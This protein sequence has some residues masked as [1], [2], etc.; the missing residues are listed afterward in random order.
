MPRIVP[1]LPC[2][3]QEAADVAL[4]RSQIH[5]VSLEHLSHCVHTGGGLESRPEGLLNVFNTV[6]TKSVAVTF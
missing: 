1:P 2:I 3:V 5:R 6:D 4:V